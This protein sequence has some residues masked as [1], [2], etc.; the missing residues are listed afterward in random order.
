MK[1]H[2]ISPVCGKI[3]DSLRSPRA[4]VA[5]R[6]SLQLLSAQQ[7]LHLYQLISSAAAWKFSRQKSDAQKHE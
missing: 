5:N 6:I 7:S 3:Q 4:S 1:I 2:Q